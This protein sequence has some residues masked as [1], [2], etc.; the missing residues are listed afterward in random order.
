MKK[1]IV[2][3]LIIVFVLLGVYTAWRTHNGSTD[4]DTFYY[5]AKR[6]VAKEPLYL[7]I[8]GVSPYIYP[9]LFACLITPLTLFSMEISS[10]IW[11]LMNLLFF[12]FSVVLCK[13]LIYGDKDP[14][15]IWKDSPFIFK[16]LFLVMT[17]ALFIDNISLLQANILIFFLVM[18]GLY[19]FIKA[20]PF[21]CG[22]F[23]AGAISIKIIPVL[24]LIYFVIKK[25]IKVV[26]AIVLGI[27]I[28]TFLLPSLF[29]GLNGTC[30]SLKTWNINMFS[31]AVSSVPNDQ[32]MGAM[33]NPVNQSVTAF[34]S[35]WFIKNDEDILWWKTECFRYPSFLINKN[36]FL[37]R[38]A[39]LFISHIIMY[40]LAVLTLL[41]CL[42]P[43]TKKNYAASNYE[44]SLIFVAC[45]FLTPILRTQ[46]LIFMLFAF[47]FFISQLRRT[48][49]YYLFFASGAAVVSIFYLLL[50]TK[51]FRI[52]GFGTIALLL[53][54]L[55]ILLKY[56][57][58]RGSGAHIARNID[59]E[60]SG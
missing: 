46:H 40:V 11:Y 2:F 35:R 52:A 51:I 26:A 6:I 31:R 34:I 60:Y 29:L 49:T 12:F 37:T 24:F 9:P 22:V 13:I 32:V 20:R 4:F 43:A 38:R 30:D 44:F 55:F 41:Y 8:N 45:L 36:G 28:F 5:A 17:A 39:T 1:S 42:K 25:E 14:G 48:E 54:W 59:V 56:H 58:V 15:D 10:F 3:S 18:A 57:K 33:F 21:L 53:L 7:E 19:Y 16:I 50:S 27:I 47:L 23:L